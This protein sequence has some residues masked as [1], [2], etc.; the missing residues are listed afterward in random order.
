MGKPRQ[1]GTGKGAMG[2]PLGD[3]RWSELL[4][5]DA[6]HVAAGRCWLGRLL[7]KVFSRVS[8]LRLRWIPEGGRE[9]A[10]C[11][12]FW[13][14]LSCAIWS[15]SP[16]KAALGLVS[17][18]TLESMRASGS[19][20]QVSARLCRENFYHFCHRHHNSLVLPYIF[21]NVTEYSAVIN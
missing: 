3:M 11:K 12:R 2:R 19:S 20:S 10:A 5:G 4:L 18:L 13:Q 14:R 6:C 17:A 9:G 1:T 15:V 21:L 16:L 8:S 7:A